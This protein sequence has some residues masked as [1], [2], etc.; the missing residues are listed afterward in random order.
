MIDANSILSKDPVLHHFT[1]I[2]LKSN[3]HHP[4]TLIYVFL[5]FFSLLLLCLPVK[6]GY[7]TPLILSPNTS[8]RCM[9]NFTTRSLYRPSPSDW[10]GLRAGLLASDKGDKLCP[11]LESKPKFLEIPTRRPIAITSTLSLFQSITNTLCHSIN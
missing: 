11:Y 1:P 10:E 5:F 7:T 8:C 6:S 4:S 2:F 9:V 3:H